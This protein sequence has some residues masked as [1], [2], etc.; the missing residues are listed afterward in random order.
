MCD[1]FNSSNL[2]FVIH[3]GDITLPKSLEAFKILKIP[4]YGVFGNNDEEEVEFL[5]KV[6]KKYNFEFR[7]NPLVVG[8]RIDL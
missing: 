2:D 3:T 1:I 4:L 6:S 7:D 5:K 8:F